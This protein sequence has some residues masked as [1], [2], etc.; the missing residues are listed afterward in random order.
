GDQPGHGPRVRQVRPQQR[1][2][3]DPVHRPLPLRTTGHR[4]PRRRTPQGLERAPQLPDQNAAKTFK[5]ARWVLL[6][7][8]EN[9]SEDQAAT[10]RKLRNRGGAVW[11]AY[12]LK[13]A[14]RAIFA[15]D[16]DETQTAT[17]LDRWCAKASRSRL[18]AF[19]RV[20]KTIRK[21][22]EG[23]MAAIGLG[24]N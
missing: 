12:S 18:P 5:G 11:R 14:F 4:R 9:L 1:P 2:Q 24:I 21:H 15:G 7:R 22:R 17:A 16:L 13:E 23:I 19:V 20:A 8:P 6:K 10:L 3:R